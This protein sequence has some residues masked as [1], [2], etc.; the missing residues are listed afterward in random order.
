[1]PYQAWTG[2][3]AH[4][5]GYDLENALTIVSFGA[6]LLDGWGIPGRFTK[7]WAEKAAGST[8]PQL[9]LI[10]IETAFSRTAARAWR[11][12]PI[13]EGSESALA[14]GLAGV[15][16]N[17]KLVPAQGP[18]PQVRLTD[19]A[20]E[21]GL[22]IDTIRDLAHLLVERRPALVIARDENPAVAALNVLLG[23]VGAR[24]G[25]V[26]RPSSLQQ[27][28][29][30]A[31]ALPKTRAVV[32]DASVRWDFVPE[33]GV[34]TFRFAAWDGGSMA[35]DWLLPAPTFLED[36]TDVPSA[37]TSGSQTYAVAPALVKNAVDLQSAAQFLTNHDA[38][39]VPVD[40][41]IHARCED[42]FR[43]RS[44]NICGR[45]THPVRQFATVQKLEE[46]L[47]QGAVWVAE[48]SSP[49]NL[50]V[51]LTEWP[52]ATPVNPTATWT[53]A[54]PAPVL[55]PLAS[56]LYIESALREAPGRNV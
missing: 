3:P 40:K 36:L 12:M 22:S 47:W 11:W 20:A 29:L 6:P 15:L 37:P 9:R 43:K 5:L 30:D 54:W 44:G 45:E 38:R 26:R 51:E 2:I 31:S 48:P 25:I 21:T 16:L 50:R 24:G 39:L 41:L 8:D 13:R 52:T 55:P 46:E 10:Q 23:A 53:T 32:I 27:K 19:V 33:A 14:S 34:E 56:K 1:M 28:T 17:Q 42:I 35:G 4:D 49:D 18:I 7:L